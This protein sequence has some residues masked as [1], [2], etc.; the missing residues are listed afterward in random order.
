[1]ATSDSNVRFDGAG[2]PLATEFALVVAATVGFALVVRTVAAASSRLGDLVAL[3][4]SLLI[5]GLL[6]GTAL[7]AGLGLLVGA[8][9]TWRDIEVGLRP[10]TREDLPA[11]FGALAGPALLVGLTALVA[12]ATGPAYSSLAKTSYAPNAALGPVLAVAGLGLFVGVPSYLLLCQVL[13]QGSFDRAVG[14]DAAAALTTVT[15]AFLLVGTDGG[16]G[17]SPFPARGRLAGTVLFALAGGIALYAADRAKR[18]W[19]RYLAA[20][21]ALALVGVTLFS[22]L[23]A[24]GSLAG[25]LFAGTQIAVLA[26]AAVTYE[27]TDSL[28]VPALAYLSLSLAHSAAVFA[29]ETGAMGL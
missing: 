29:A 13:V 2:R 18:R 27:R 24:V 19:V 21:P 12:D 8:Y 28:V 9:A 3:P 1:M 17:L 6:H 4:D 15:T 14:G 25:A 26:L 5:D 16:G 11:A 22:A 7:L 23:A 20:V 10:P